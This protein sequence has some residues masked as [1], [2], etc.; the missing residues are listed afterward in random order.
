VL[1]K[2]AHALPDALQLQHFGTS[3]ALS[4]TRPCSDAMAGHGADIEADV[5][6]PR[7]GLAQAIRTLDHDS[8]TLLLP[9]Y[10]RKQGVNLISLSSKRR[11]GVE[12][13]LDDEEDRVIFEQLHKLY[14]RIIT[15]YRELWD[16]FMTQT[17]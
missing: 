16:K 10:M 5:E 9:S 7:L 4:P 6:E 8:D 11:R 2:H 3:L 13:D 14:L 12:L 1:C 17:R 15:G